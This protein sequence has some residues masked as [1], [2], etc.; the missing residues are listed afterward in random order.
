MNGLH[1][2]GLEQVSLA[3]VD[4]RPFFG[5]PRIIWKVGVSRELF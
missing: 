1:A 5:K 4:D 3:M 2:R